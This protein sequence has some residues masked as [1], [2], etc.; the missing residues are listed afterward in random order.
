MISILLATYNGERYIAE[1]IESLLTQTV[2]DF[3]LY[4]CDDRSTDNTYAII[5]DYA[6]RYA[7]KIFAKQNEVNSGGAKLNFMKMILE[8]KDDYVMLCDQDDVWLPNKIEISLNKMH[9]MESRYGAAMP[10]LVHTDLRVVDQNLHTM[11]HSYAKMSR[12]KFCDRSLNSLLTINIAAG[13]TELY[14]RALADLIT[15][16]PAYMMVHDWWVLL[17]AASLGRIGTVYEPT[18]LYRQHDSN[19]LGAKNVLSLGYVL[20]FVT[21]FKKMIEKVCNTYEQAESFLCVYKNM[22]S[23]EQRDLL[24]A[25]SSIPHYSRIRRLVT[26]IK[27]KTWM[28]GVSRRFAQVTVLLSERRVRI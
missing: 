16:E 27:R 12:K 15:D 13:C 2:Q 10:L 4:I 7:G 6:K 11:Y 21:N 1:Q 8:H 14:N 18:I 5:S 28:H 9:E 26:V 19:D 3:T 17:V 22:L 23:D 25:Y 20:H 24:S